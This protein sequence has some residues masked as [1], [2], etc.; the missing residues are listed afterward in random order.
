MDTGSPFL[1]QS[2]A[3]LGS[4]APRHLS[5]LTDFFL[6]FKN[7]L[8]RDVLVSSAVTRVKNVIMRDVTPYDLLQINNVTGERD[9][10]IFR[11]RRRKRRI[12]PKRRKIST[13]VNVTRSLRL[14]FL[15]FSYAIL[16]RLCHF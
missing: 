10:T 3:K 12:A 1:W 9:A 6:R 8:F 7:H 2:G 13:K 4:F 15:N 14:W 5:L 16:K 11:V